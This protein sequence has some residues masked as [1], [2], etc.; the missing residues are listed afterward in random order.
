MKGKR[1]SVSVAAFL[2]VLLI[3][4]PVFAEDATAAVPY[5][6][7]TATGEVEAAP[8]I[9]YLNFQVRTE[10]DSSAAAQQSNAKA[11][12]TAI[13]LL[14]AK[15]L[16]RDEIFT[17]YYRSYS[18]T[19]K[20]TVP[21]E[22]DSAAASGGP[23]R[24]D[25]PGEGKEITVYVTESTLRATAPDIAKVG[26]LLADLATVPAVRVNNVDYSL[27]NVLQY[28]QAAIT[29]AIREARETIDITAAA[30]GAEIAGLRTIRVDFNSRYYYPVYAREMLADEVAEAA[31]QPQNPEDIKVAATV[32][33]SY[34]V[35]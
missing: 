1:F 3:A 23:V 34:N 24:I 10:A 31:P 26:S 29:A 28:K 4:A 27:K 13:D 9:A 14:V 8:D 35:K 19:K 16:A 21:L 25:V 32:Y 33:L 17:T 30:L 15:G 22:R 12:N 11:V 20:E 7:T 5:I 2:L 6:E 18:Y